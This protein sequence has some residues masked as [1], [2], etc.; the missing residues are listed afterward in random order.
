MLNS[1]SLLLHLRRRAGSADSMKADTNLPL[2]TK[3]Q[4]LD[5]RDEIIAAKAKALTHHGRGKTLS[6]VDKVINVQKERSKLLGVST[7]PEPRFKP[8][9]MNDL[10]R[11]ERNLRGFHTKTCRNRR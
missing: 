6:T 4:L 2:I 11:H 10:H 8:Y 5:K 3:G 9:S 7:G 1:L